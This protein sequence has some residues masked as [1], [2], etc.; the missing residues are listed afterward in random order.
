M[1][2]GNPPYNGYAGNGGGRGTGALG[3]PTARPGGCGVPR[4]RGLMTCTCVF[5]GWPNDGLPRRPGKAW[6]ASFPTIRGWTAC[7]VRG[8]GNAIWMPLT[9][10]RID[11]LQRRS[12]HRTGKVAHRTARRTRETVFSIRGRRSGGDSGSVRPLP[13]L[14]RKAGG[15]ASHARVK[16]ASLVPRPSSGVRPEER[17]RALLD[18]LD[19]PEDR[20][21]RALQHAGA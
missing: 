10:I 3:R 2:L 13:L 6:S 19:G 15:V 16:R 18:S 8:C 4:A 9:V 1:I 20:A 5:S 12:N 11:N 17:R 7:R 14:V 21:G